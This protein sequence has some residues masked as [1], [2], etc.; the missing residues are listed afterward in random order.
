[1][2]V[3]IAI[4]GRQLFQRALRQARRGPE[5]AKRR[6]LRETAKW[7]GKQSVAELARRNRLPQKTLTRGR[8]GKAGRMRWTITPTDAN[9]WVGTQPIKASY[10]GNLRQTQQGVSA[11]RPVRRFPGAFLATL[12]SGHTGVFE[13]AAH[14]THRRANNVWG[15]TQ[16]P[17]EEQQVELEGAEDAQRHVQQG[18]PGRF[19]HELQRA[20]RAERFKYGRK[21]R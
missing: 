16:L 6:A 1:M 21:F 12:R 11:G 8:R 13:R 4:P 2:P 20:L 18:I 3:R 9:V 5:T 15:T 14:A 19:R 7:A 10:L 17:I